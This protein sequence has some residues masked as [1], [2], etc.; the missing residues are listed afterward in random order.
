MATHNPKTT[1]DDTMTTLTDSEIDDALTAA[2]DAFTLDVA[3]DSMLT[4]HGAF[5][6]GTPEESIAA[7]GAPWFQ[8][9]RAVIDAPSADDVDGVK[10][11]HLDPEPPQSV[12]FEAA[13]EADDE[14]T[15]ELTFE[16]VEEYED[17]YGTVKV[18]VDTP[19]PWDTPDDMTPANEVIKSLEWDDH[20]RTF[21]DTREAWTMDQSGVDPLREIATEAGYQWIDSR[22]DGEADKTDEANDEQDGLDQ[23]TEVAEEGDRVSVRYRKK[24]GSG[25]G[26]KAGTVTTS[27][28]GGEDEDGYERTQGVVFQR[29]DEQYNKIKRDDN[30]TPSIFSMSQYPFMGEVISVEVVPKDE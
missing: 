14:E 11:G 8:I 12:V 5:E 13:F 17:S 22:D 2:T 3:P 25:I 9:I 23:L 29:S 26:T 28:S 20:H 30:G 6:L 27:S 10:P 15:D 1:A 21:D 7:I 19:A 24:N 4:P 18:V 16:V